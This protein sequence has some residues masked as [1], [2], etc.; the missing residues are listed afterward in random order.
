MAYD[1]RIDPPEPSWRGLASCLQFLTPSALQCWTQPVPSSIC[2]TVSER[3]TGPHICC[4][5]AQLIVDGDVN[6]LSHILRAYGGM[7]SLNDLVIHPLNGHDLPAQ[8][9][10]GVN[11]RLSVLR[12]RLYGAATQLKVR[13]RDH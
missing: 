7:G 2:C 13:G 6:G 3:N 12:S 1:G 9:I 5:A 4:A 10:E 8:D 11:S